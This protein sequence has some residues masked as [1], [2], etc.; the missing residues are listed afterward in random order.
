[1]M[2]L[3]GAACVML[4]YI[5]LGCMTVRV[6]Y[7]CKHTNMSNLTSAAVLDKECTRL[8]TCPSYIINHILFKV[9]GLSATKERTHLAH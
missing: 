4:P 2:C 9:F 5:I 1:M 8:V 3:G 7:R 6:A